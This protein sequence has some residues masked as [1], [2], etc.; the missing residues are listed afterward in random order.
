[1]LSMTAADCSIRVT[2]AIS[3]PGRPAMTAALFVAALLLAGCAGKP[4]PA[5]VPQDEATLGTLPLPP[6]PLQCVPYARLVSGIAI[7]G[8]AWTW[9]DAADGRYRRG[10]QPRPGAVLV[11][12]RTNRL[13]FGHVAV[14]QRQ[15]DPRE[16]LITHANW[17]STPA[18]R[19]RATRDVRVVDVSPGNDWS[20]LR[21]WNAELAVFGQPYLA[22]GFIYPAAYASAESF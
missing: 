21:V 19:G 11:F 4:Q 8:D 6:G 20:R 9:W 18:T 5:A 3:G 7:R 10:S 15:V 2:R 17:G 22:Q 1:M 12:H 16:I 14:V 13:P